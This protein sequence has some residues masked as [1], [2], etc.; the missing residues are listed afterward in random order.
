MLPP[1]IFQNI[2]AGL[3]TYVTEGVSS[4]ATGLPRLH[5]ADPSASLDK[6][7]AIQLFHVKL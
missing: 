7:S 1:L 6:S 4:S 2:S 5:R 3:S